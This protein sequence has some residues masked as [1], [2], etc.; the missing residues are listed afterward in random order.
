[1]ARSKIVPAAALL[2]LSAGVAGCDDRPDAGARGTGS[3]GHTEAEAVVAGLFEAINANDPDRVLAHYDPGAELVQLAC[4]EVR[5]GFHQVESIIRMWQAD[6]PG[7]RIEHQVV[8]AVEVGPAAAVVAA[9]GR[10][11][12][13]LAL[14]WTFVLRRDDHG[15]WRIVQEHQSWAGCREPRIHL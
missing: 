15:D 1:M 5:H 9:R 10:N 7:T 13:G 14:F 6:H 2:L 4:T 12:E 8:R 3:A 11:H